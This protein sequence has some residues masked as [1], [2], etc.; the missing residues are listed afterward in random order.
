MA[1]LTIYLTQAQTKLGDNA[2]VNREG[3]TTYRVRTNTVEEWHKPTFSTWQLGSNP[4]IDD[5]YNRSRIV[6]TH[7]F[8]NVPDGVA[9]SLK[10]ILD[11]KMQAHELNRR[12]P[13]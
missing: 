9:N 5:I 8:N 1:D 2:V 13:R 7:L 10:N 6:A 4:S 11:R 3:N 12:E